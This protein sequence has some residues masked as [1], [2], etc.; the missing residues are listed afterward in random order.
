MELHLPP[1]RERRD[2]IPHL[3][4]HAL[5]S[6]SQRK[7]IPRPAITRKAM[8]ILLTNDWPGNVRELRNAVERAAEEAGGATLTAAH[9]TLQSPSISDSPF[10]SAQEEYQ[11]IAA[12]LRQT[13]GNVSAAARRLDTSRNTLYRRMKQ[14]GIE[15]PRSS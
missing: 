3:V 6:W 8:E 9:L 4:A 12:A 13:K 1:L 15:R 7:D 2:D 10:P 5:T 14:L 11:R